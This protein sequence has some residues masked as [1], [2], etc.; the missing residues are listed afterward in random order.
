MSL[1]VLGIVVAVVL[2]VLFNA[3]RW[4]AL[5]RGTRAFGRR[6]QE[7]YQRPASQPQ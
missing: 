2:L 6:L 1:I 5:G 4:R 7:G 3:R